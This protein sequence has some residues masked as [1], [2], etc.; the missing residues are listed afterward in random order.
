MSFEE[1]DVTSLANLQSDLYRFSSG[2]EYG[3]ILGIKGAHRKHQNNRAIKKRAEEIYKEKDLFKHKNLY[4]AYEIYADL[5]KE[6]ATNISKSTL[7]AK[8]VPEFREF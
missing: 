5:K 2:P 4:A 3:D 8:W 1:Q 7:E 6:N